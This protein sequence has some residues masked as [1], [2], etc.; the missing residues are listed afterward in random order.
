MAADNNRISA[1]TKRLGRE[2]CDPKSPLSLEKRQRSTH[3]GENDPDIEP[4]EIEQNLT[5]V[6]V[7]LIAV[8]QMVER[9]LDARASLRALVGQQDPMAPTACRELALFD[10]Q[11]MSPPGAERMEVLP[12]LSPDAPIEE[13]A[14]QR[15]R[16]AARYRA[17]A[18]AHDCLVEAGV[19]GDAL[20]DGL[21]CFL[22]AA[23]PGEATPSRRTIRETYLPRGREVITRAASIPETL[24]EEIER[25]TGI[26]ADEW[27]IE[28]HEIFQEL[29]EQWRADH[30]RGVET[31]LAGRWGASPLGDGETEVSS[32]RQ[33]VGLLEGPLSLWRELTDTNDENEASQPAHS[34]VGTIVEKIG[35]Q[36]PDIATGDLEE[37]LLD[38][39]AFRLRAIEILSGYHNEHR[40]WE[41]LA[42]VSGA[43]Y[44]ALTVLEAYAGWTVAFPWYRGRPRLIDL[45][46]T[47]QQHRAQRRLHIDVL[48]DRVVL[49]LFIHTLREHELP[50]GRTWLWAY[51][52][53]GA[54][55][56]NPNAD[57]LQL[58]DEASLHAQ[59]TKGIRAL[60][61]LGVPV[62]PTHQLRGD[63][64]RN[65]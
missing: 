36:Y 2:M 34:A 19:S 1:A 44:A 7:S 24:D 21:R 37:R 46:S 41:K 30:E 59:Y 14:G 43:A 27:F 42:G 65:S 56:G 31:P 48:V 13:Q 54:A 38:V 51:R 9:R 61:N 52:L 53:L 25:E 23:F 26:T 45:L 3:S 12:Q 4:T 40:H 55:A 18:E 15:E 22:R 58:I 28:S 6:L 10:Q 33:A 39:C 5:H 35:R 50:R 20:W 8:E 49:V 60:E 17:V 32:G 29:C 11:Q 64:R 47:R 57:E 63:A 16:R 62:P